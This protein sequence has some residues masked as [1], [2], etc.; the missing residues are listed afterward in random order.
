MESRN[1]TSNTINKPNPLHA[2]RELDGVALA[3]SIDPE[4]MRIPFMPMQSVAAYMKST[5]LFTQYCDFP[6]VSKKQSGHIWPL[7]HSGQCLFWSH[8]KKCGGKR[9]SKGSIGG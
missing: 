7:P 4:A 8:N 6:G 2:E 3:C 5:R 1:S 9:I